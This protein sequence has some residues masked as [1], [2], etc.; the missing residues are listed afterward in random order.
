[1]TRG[2]RREGKES[3]DRNRNRRMVYSYESL[4]IVGISIAGTLLCELLS[5][6][7]IYRK[8]N[9]KQLVSSITR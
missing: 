6:F 1:M 8:S 2:G 3:E 9:Y 7:L 4:K 5:W